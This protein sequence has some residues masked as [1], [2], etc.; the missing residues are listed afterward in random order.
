[1]HLNKTLTN[2]CSADI[3]DVILTIS[4]FNELILEFC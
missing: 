4:F 1:M 2:G 3:F